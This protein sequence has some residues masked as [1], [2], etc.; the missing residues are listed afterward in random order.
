MTTGIRTVIYP[1]R[2][3]TRAKAL[4]SGLTGLEPST[5][6]PYYVG[7]SV[8]DQEVGLDPN[9]HSQGM[10]G[11]VCYWHVD[12]I[13]LR[14]KALVEAGGRV[15]QEVRDVGGGKLIAAVDDADGNVIGLLQP[16]G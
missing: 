9:G 15:T 14:V 13:E 3:L 5:D 12:D 7:Y 16:P 6:E 1:V 8:G 10:T 2:D 4:Y 11:P